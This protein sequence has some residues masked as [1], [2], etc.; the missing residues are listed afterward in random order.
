M[1]K[2]FVFN[3]IPL[4]GAGRQMRDSNRQVEFVGQLLK[5]MFPQ[6]ATVAICPTA[7][8]LNQQMALSRISV[9]PDL[10]P[11]LSNRR[12]CKVRGLMRYP[13][14]DKAFIPGH[15]INAIRNGDAFCL[16]GI[17]A[18]PDQSGRYAP[19][20][21]R[22]LEIPNQFALLGIDRN[23]W[24]TRLLIGATL[25]SQILHLAI[26]IRIVALGQPLPVDAQRIVPL[27]QQTSDCIR[28]NTITTPFQLPAQFTRGLARPLQAVNRITRGVIFQQLVQGG[29]DA[30]RLFS[31]R[32]RPA[33]G[34]RTRLAA[35]AR[36]TFWTSARPRRMVGRLNPVIS[37]SRSILPRPQCSAN[38]PAKRRRLFSFNVP[39]TRLIA[40]CSFAVPPYGWSQQMAQVHTCSSWP[41]DAASLDGWSDADRQPRLCA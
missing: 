8:G 34:R 30:W 33:P 24:K 19:S 37:L 5:F 3:R 28:A 23:H 17:V 11:P 40:R 13:D 35:L 6:P 2:Q 15:V 39:R 38:K 1:A 31:T 14:N 18:L 21:A 25:A 20:P 10:A 36:S 41:M 32:S 7:I 22:I 12:D 29:Q 16:T 4:R 26:P 9:L 27:A